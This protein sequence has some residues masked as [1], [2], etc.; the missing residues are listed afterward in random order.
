M[1]KNINRS[2]SNILETILALFLFIRIMQV[3]VIYATVLDILLI[4][5]TKEGINNTIKEFAA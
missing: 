2:I 5:V 4:N 3:G 1:L